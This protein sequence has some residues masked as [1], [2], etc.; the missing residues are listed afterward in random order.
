MVKKDASRLKR[1]KLSRLNVLG[2]PQSLNDRANKEMKATLKGISKNKKKTT[3]TREETTKLV[4]SYCGKW[5]ELVAQTTYKISTTITDLEAPNITCGDSNKL[6]FECSKVWDNHSATKDNVLNHVKLI[7]QRIQ[8]SK[9]S[10][11]PLN[12]GG[13]SS[14]GGGGAFKMNTNGNVNGL[15]YLLQV[16]TKKR[17]RELDDELLL[18]EACDKEK[19]STTFEERL[20]KDATNESGIY[21]E[22]DED[23]QE[24]TNQYLNLESGKLD[25]TELTGDERLDM[26]RELLD[27]FNWEREDN[28]IEFHEIMLRTVLPK[29]FTK[30]WDTDYERIMRMFKMEKHTAETFIICPRRYG[31]TVSVAMF[32]AA[33]LYMVPNASIA[34]FS[35]S[36]RTSGKMM[37]AV[38][39]FMRELPFFYHV[40]FETKNSECIKIV[41]N[42]NERS[43]WSYPGTVAVCVIFF[44]QKNRNNS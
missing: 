26:F 9:V 37:T 13:S 14:G 1:S 30:E 24:T 19:K 27:M 40:V 3:Q 29:I 18:C 17:E 31:K 16:S 11:T 25:T 4:S 36:K 38:Y 35:T 12:G 7:D 28:Q 41:M 6:F 34:I 21:I 42:G 20:P 2:L 33:Y 44:S 23:F 22:D 43:V 10:E 32:C 39:G 15:S 5:L 8:N